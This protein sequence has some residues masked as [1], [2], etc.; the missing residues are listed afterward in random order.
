MQNLSYMKDKTYNALIHAKRWQ[1]IRRAKLTQQP[2][3]E[4]CYKQGRITAASE[5][6]HINPAER[7]A[8]YSAKE[9]LMYDPHNLMSVCHDCHVAI[10]TD[11]GRSGKKY[12]EARTKEQLAD[13]RDKFLK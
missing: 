11:M 5:V 13:F 10:H 4:R 6:H 1:T 8:T 2:L 3:C 7:G 12:T 9:S